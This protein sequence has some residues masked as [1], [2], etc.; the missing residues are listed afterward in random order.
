MSAYDMLRTECFRSRD[1][2]AASGPSMQFG[3]DFTDSNSIFPHS[4]D[5]TGLRGIFPARMIFSIESSV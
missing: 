3:K 2:K 1:K 5:D 4:N